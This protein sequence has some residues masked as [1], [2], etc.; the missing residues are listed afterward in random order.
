M[1]SDWVTVQPSLKPLTEKLEPTIESVVGVIE[2]LLV[3]LNVT[4]KVLNI[5]KAFL[6]GI[7][8]PL[9][10]LVEQIIAEIKTLISDLRQL[11]IY[12]HGDYELFT[13]GDYYSDLVGGYEVYERR[14]LQRLLDASDPS[15]PNFSSNSAVVALFIYVSSGE[16]VLLIKLTLRKMV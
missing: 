11:G 1:S 12:M 15:R 7:L 4:Q 16:V 3:V 6:I 13:S 5:I 8:D 10:P 2:V 9:R 14:M